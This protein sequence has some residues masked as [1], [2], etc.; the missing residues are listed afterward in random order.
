MK[1]SLALLGLAA[2]SLTACQLSSTGSSTGEASTVMTSELQVKLAPLE[3]F[4]DLK[5]G[6]ARF[7][8]GDLT[9]RDYLTQADRT[10]TAGQYPKAVVLSCLDSRVPPEIIF[11]QGIGDIFVG[12]IAGNFEN[13]DMLGSM[14]FATAAAGVPLIVVLG[15]GSCGA[16][17]GAADAVEL[18]NLTGMLEH[19]QPAIDAAERKVGGPVAGSNAQLVA[20]AVEANVEQTMADITANS[21]VIAGLVASG[22]VA[23]VGGVY[24]L[25]SGQVLWMDN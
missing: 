15:H 25:A 7:I 1:Y 12:R 23:I 8:A 14:E 11:D 10:A 20:A 6:N 9:P 24:D 13:S 5:A 17:K 4:E 22:D 2:A 18:G 19:L 21:E 3:A 16:I